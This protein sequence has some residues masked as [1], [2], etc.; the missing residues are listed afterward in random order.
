MTTLFSLDPGD[1][2]SEAAANGFREFS[3]NVPFVAYTTLQMR[4]SARSGRLDGFVFEYQQYQNTPELIQEYVFVPYGVRHDNPVF[5]LGNLSDAKHTLL[6]DFIAYAK[7]PA[8]QTLA[9]GYGF[10]GLPDYKSDSRVTGERLAQAQRLWKENKNAD[11]DLLVVFVADLSGSMTGEPLE[12]L[13][14]AI[15]QGAKY[16]S[17]DSYVGLVSFNENAVINLPIG[18]MDMLQRQYFAG[19]VNNW[20]SMGN[21]AMYNGIITGL[22]MLTEARAQN[23]TAKCML[24]VL[25]DG[26][27]TGGRADILEYDDVK[28]VI[29]E[30]GIPVYTI[31]FNANISVLSEISSLNEAASVNADNED[32]VYRLSQLFNAE[33]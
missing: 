26:E 23:P 31:G 4:T 1:I 8:N 18:K 3:A 19:A 9:E 16:I 33:M 29:F 14:E 12:R 11:R 30:V 32:V 13:K 17:D 6:S 7:S 10:N 27:N 20:K 5:E 21:T 25:T 2:L 28:D 24:F 15:T 22:Q